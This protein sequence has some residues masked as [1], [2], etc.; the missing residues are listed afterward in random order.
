MI[1]RRPISISGQ[2]I[3]LMTSGR[4]DQDITG[5]ICVP[6]VGPTLLTQLS[7]I[8]MALVLSIPATI[9]MVAVTSVINI[10]SV[11]NANS[12]TSFDCGMLIPF[13]LTGRTA[14]GCRICRKLFRITFSSI[15]PLM[16]LKP[17]LVLPA[18]APRYMMTPNMTHVICGHVPASSLNIPVVVINDTTWNSAHLNDFSKS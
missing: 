3:H 9:M 2:R 12:A 1:S 10:V 6:N 17:P 13:I 5:P 14:F 16:H 8:V 18:H 15:T 7:A 4:P 11:K